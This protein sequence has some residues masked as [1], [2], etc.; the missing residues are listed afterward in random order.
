VTARPG[1][2]S[3][4]PEIIKP[5]TPKTTIRL[6]LLAKAGEFLHVVVFVDMIRGHVMITDVNRP[7][8]QN[9]CSGHFEC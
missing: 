5:K 3:K 2:E 6:Q 4:I 7:F 9:P 8:T 1:S